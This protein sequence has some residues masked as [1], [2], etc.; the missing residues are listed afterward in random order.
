MDVALFQ[1]DQP[2]S[3]PRRRRLTQ[4]A[5][6]PDAAD[7]FARLCQRSALPLLSRVDPYAD[8]ALTSAE[9][10]QLLAELSTELGAATSDGERELLAAVL[11]LAER[12]ALGEGL[13]L[14]LQG[15]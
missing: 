13:E 12:C 2:G 5:V 11:A 15:D 9:M 7:L 10:E 1:V 14:H 6:V 3:S 4:L 8:L